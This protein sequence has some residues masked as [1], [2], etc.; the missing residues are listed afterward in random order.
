MRYKKFAR[1]NYTLLLLDPP[2][3]YKDKGKAGKRGASQQYKTLSFHQLMELPIDEISAKNSVLM[4]WTSDTHV[5]QSIQLMRVWGFEYKRFS[6]VWVKV[7][8]DF[9]KQRIML[10][11]HTRSNVEVVLLGVKGKGIKRKDKGIRQV[12][13][14]VPGK[15]SKKPDEVKIRLKKLYGKVRKVEA[16]ARNVKH[17]DDGW[18]YWG[19]QV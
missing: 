11:R 1:S 4:M 6:F 18:D 17:L 8:K 10:G 3:K 14:A 7:T 16:F 2:R 19:D 5:F 15:H 12:I 9:Q 13:F